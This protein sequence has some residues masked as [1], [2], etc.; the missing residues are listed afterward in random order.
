MFI[1]DT[2]GKIYQFL[3]FTSLVKATK[4]LEYTI[5]TKDFTRK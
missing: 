4:S 5:T 1:L 3:H 2:Y